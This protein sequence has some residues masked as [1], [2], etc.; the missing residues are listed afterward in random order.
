MPAR[1]K[2]CCVIGC[3]NRDARR[4]AI[5]TDEKIRKVW[6]ERIDNRKLLELEKYQIKHVRI[7]QCHF[8]SDCLESNGKLKKGSLPAIDLSGYTADHEDIFFREPKKTIFHDITLKD[9]YEIGPSTSFG[10]SLES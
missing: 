2:T 6:L 8:H 4:Y 3:E 7:C 5:T 9:V 10:L 1:V